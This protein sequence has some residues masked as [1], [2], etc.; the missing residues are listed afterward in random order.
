ML[1]FEEENKPNQMKMT[2]EVVVPTGFVV[3]PIDQYDQLLLD[4]TSRPVIK[5]ELS[6][7]T[8]N[9]IEVV[10]DR[11]WLYEAAMSIMRRRYTPEELAQFDIIPVDDVYVGD[12]K[13]AKRKPVEPDTP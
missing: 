11:D 3:L 2:A 6:A 12:V 5:V 7:F 1:S 13:I 9:A 4:A 10:I 8:K